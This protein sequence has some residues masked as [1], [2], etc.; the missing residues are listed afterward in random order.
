[1]ASATLLQAVSSGSPRL[2]VFPPDQQHL[3]QRAEVAPGDL[4]RVAKLV[5]GRMPDQSDPHQVLASFRLQQD[6]GVHIG[7]VIRVPLYAA[8]QRNAA[9]SGTD[10]R[11]VGPEVTL[12]VVGIE[13]AEVEFPF[14][15]TSGYG[16][17]ATQA[18]AR[19]VNP[20]A[21]LSPWYLVR[22]RG[23]PADVPRFQ[24]QARALGVPYAGDLDTAASAIGAAIH[25]Q[26]VLMR[27]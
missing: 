19:T 2:C 11:P 17:Y 27:S 21:V 13:A 9:P 15:N 8:S 16:L 14:A 26:V 24:A 22:L 5:A 1:M 10:V 23:G 7:T 20:N 12:R 6:A 4:S 25:P 18:F 3:L